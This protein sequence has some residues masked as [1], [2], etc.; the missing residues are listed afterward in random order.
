VLPRDK[1]EAAFSDRG[2]PHIP[3]V[4]PYEGIFLRDHWEQ[5]TDHPWW[6]AQ[7]PHPGHQL[8]WRR[9]AIR[10]IGQDWF[11]LPDGRPSSLWQEMEV[12]AQP[13][14]A[15][16]TD[17]RSG[18][19]EMVARPRV[20][21][22]TA[23]GE[24]ESVHPDRPPHTV[25]EIDRALP[26]PSGD[27]A[28]ALQDGSG[29]VARALLAEFG[30]THWPI[31]HV[32][33]PL[34][35]SYGLWGFEGMMTMLLERPDLVHHV[36]ERGLARQT[37]AVRRAALLG[38]A[39]IWIEDC[40]TD[41]IS[42]SAF[43]TF[44]VA[45]LKPLIQEIR[46]LGMKSIYYY[47]GD[48]SGKWPHLLSVG[49]DALSLEESKKGFCIEIEDVVA[50]VQGQCVVL[51]NV[52]AIE[53]MPHASEAELRRELAR[54]IAAGRRNGSRFIMSLGSPVTPQTPLER[55]RLYCE[56]ARQLGAQ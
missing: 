24:P 15:V 28:S 50:R 10:A 13:D 46:A 38:A 27:P 34:W 16:F 4:I 8:A 40:L 3:V 18:S 29:D 14:K 19:R 47:C 23:R 31:Q 2:A 21:G 36:C 33:S 44:D 9:D 39:G 37:H 55:V 41:L 45:Y 30:G 20:G 56:L 32:S 43:E 26:L 48:P 1:I 11:S 17:R 12:E 5:F 49:A 52:D 6:Y 51:G 22:W 53:L 54:Q 35:L 42:P 7:S 25:E